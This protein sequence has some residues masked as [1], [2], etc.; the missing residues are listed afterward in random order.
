MVRDIASELKKEVIFTIEG[1]GITADKKILEEMRDPWMHM[2]RNSL[3]HGI[4]LPEEREKAGKPRVASIKLTALHSATTISIILEDD[5]K[6]LNEESI[7]ETAIRKNLFLKKNLKTLLP[8]RF[9][10]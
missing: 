10:N 7:L 4:E 8:H 5:G 9:T 6:G 3:D 2:I 1:A